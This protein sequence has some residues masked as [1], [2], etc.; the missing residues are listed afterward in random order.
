[1]TFILAG[2]LRFIYSRCMSRDHVVAPEPITACHTW[3]T[4]AAHSWHANHIRAHK[5]LHISDHVI[6]SLDDASVTAVLL[7]EAFCDTPFVTKFV[8]VVRMV[9]D[10]SV[11]S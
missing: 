3:N 9:Y 8:C 2:S 6:T 4:V 1:M 10:L 5:V 7:R 11:H